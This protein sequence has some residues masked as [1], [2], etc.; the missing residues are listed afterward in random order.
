MGEGTHSPGTSSDY[1]RVHKMMSLGQMRDHMSLKL[2]EAKRLWMIS[3][4]PEV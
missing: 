1:F 2:T 4:D 3:T